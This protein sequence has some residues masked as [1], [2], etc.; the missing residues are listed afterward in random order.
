MVTNPHPC[1]ESGS[2]VVIDSERSGTTTLEVSRTNEEGSVG[3]KKCS[4]NT[5]QVHN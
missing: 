4:S 1:R 3:G 5:T 2:A